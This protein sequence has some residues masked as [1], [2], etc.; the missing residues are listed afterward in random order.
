MRYR[1]LGR[2]GSAVSALTLKIGSDALAGGPSRA[3]SLVF[4]GLEAGINTVHLTSADPVLAEAVGQALSQ[5]DRKLIQ[6]SVSLGRVDARRGGRDFSP[7]ALTGSI[8]RILHAS[9][10]GWIDLALLD[11]PGED[12]MPQTALNAL[13]AQRTAGRIRMLGIA[14]DGEVMDAY[15]STGAFDVLATSY[16]VN[17]PWQTKHRIRAA[18]ERDMAVVAYGY[19]PEELDTAKKAETVHVPRKGLFGLGGRP[20]HDPLAGAGTFAFLHRTHGWSAEHICLAFALTDPS[21]ATVMVDASHSERIEALAAV[22]ERDLP[23]G[24]AAQIEMARVRMAAA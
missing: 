20:K 17:S 3:Q 12:E 10:L 22:P 14:G 9:G 8:D 4:A 19:F 1:P 18:L 6:L 7:E 13:K 16:H 23:P 2:S 15:I 24:L 21:V 11:E 5:V